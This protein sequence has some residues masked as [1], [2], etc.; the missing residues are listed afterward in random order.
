MHRLIKFAQRQTKLVAVA[1]AA[2]VLSGAATAA[3]RAAIPDS[4]GII[5]SCYRASGLFAGYLRVIDS[6]SQNCSNGETGLNWSQAGSTQGPQIIHARTSVPFDEADND[7][8]LAIPEF[9][10]LQVTVCDPG[11]DPEDPYPNTSVIYKNTSARTIEVSSSNGVQSLSTGQT[12]AG[13]PVQLGYSDTT[14]YHLANITLSGGGG[15]TF[16]SQDACHFMAQAIISE[17]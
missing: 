17:D 7:T 6:P 5:H 1:V 12:Y 16:G 4:S 3:V 9:G 11:A 15:S 8:V 2:V 13:I 10:E 14:G